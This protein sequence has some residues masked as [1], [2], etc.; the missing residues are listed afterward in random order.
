MSH[1]ALCTAAGCVAMKA[2]AVFP[3]H[4]RLLDSC[5]CMQ[6]Y[7]CRFTHKS[8]DSLNYA[9]AAAAEASAV[10]EGLHQSGQ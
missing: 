4:A 10:K 3:E 1:G 6:Y 5:N 8:N 7:K 2:A 9:A